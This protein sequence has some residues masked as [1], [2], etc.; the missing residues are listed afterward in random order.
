MRTFAAGRG[1]EL[2]QHQD[3]AERGEGED[4]HE[5][6]RHFLDKLLGGDHQLGGRSSGHCTNLSAF[7]FSE[8]SGQIGYRKPIFQIPEP[9]KALT[10][11]LLYLFLYLLLAAG[12]PPSSASP[13]SASRTCLNPMSDAPLPSVIS[14]VEAVSMPMDT[15]SC[16]RKL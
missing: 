4:E 10:A 9:K 2:R 6:Q 16:R 1:G 13:P 5:G 11:I 8:V 14:C 12:H 7:E 3:Q 15:V